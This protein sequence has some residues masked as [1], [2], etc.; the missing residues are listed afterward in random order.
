MFGTHT[1]GSQTY[2]NWAEWHDGNS[3]QTG[4]SYENNSGLDET[5]TFC[6]L[7]YDIAHEMNNFLFVGN[8][9]WKVNGVQKIPEGTRMLYRS[10]RGKYCQ[11]KIIE[12]YLPLPFIP[13][14]LTSFNNRLIVFGSAEF[15]IVNPETMILEQVISGYGIKSKL[16]I[17]TTLQGVFFANQNNMYVFDGQQ[18][19]P[20]GDPLMRCPDTTMRGVIS[21]IGIMPY[22]DLVSGNG[23]Y[24]GIQRV[25]YAP[26][27][28]SVMFIYSLNEPGKLYAYVF[29]LTNK[30]WSFQ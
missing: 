23:A 17:L 19:V 27:V 5:L 11:F 4:S 8:V 7:G 26:M 18:V 13:L 3:V 25:V 24:V 12:D 29:S 21:D 10:M 1:S 16:C 14:A 2:D 20:I 30:T 6:N 15:A 28:N 9:G 22:E